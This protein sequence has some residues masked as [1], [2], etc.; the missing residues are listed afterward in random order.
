MHIY[1]E[2]YEE[3]KR[4]QHIKY[5]FLLITKIHAMEDTYAHFYLIGFLICV[6]VCMGICAHGCW[7]YK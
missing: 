6:C 3:N 7:S 5:L 1:L 2:R 4:A